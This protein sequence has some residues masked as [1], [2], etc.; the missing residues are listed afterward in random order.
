MA[1]TFNHMAAELERKIRDLEELFKGTAKALVGAIDEKDPY[2]RGHSE[3][4]NRYS[5]TLAQYHGL[6]DDDL[7]DIDMSSLLHDVG[8]IG[9][10]DEDLRKPGQLT[11]DE[12]EEMKKHTVKG[13][14]IMAPIR[15]M[16]KLLPGLRNHHERWN[17]GGYPDGLKGDA[18][19]LMARII[20]VADSFDAMTTDRPYQK[21][22]TFDQAHARVNELKG[23]AFDDHVVASFNRAYRDGKITPSPTGATPKPATQPVT[24]PE[25]EASPV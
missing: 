2:T 11:P 24:Q 22:M 15:Q 6:P 23:T 9:V 13:E 21:A 18:I 1:D 8:K 7:K 19:P 10:R 3:R 5:K 12:F 16:E 25:P 20:A 4:V 14:K 17:G